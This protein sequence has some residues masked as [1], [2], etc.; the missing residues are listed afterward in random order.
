[1]ITPVLMCIRGRYKNK[2]KDI[3]CSRWHVY[4]KTKGGSSGGCTDTLLLVRVVIK[5]EGTSSMLHSQPHT[6]TGSCLLSYFKLIPVVTEAVGY[7]NGERVV[8]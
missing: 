6:R 8:V 7:A 5:R 4:S 2:E 1:M 3:L